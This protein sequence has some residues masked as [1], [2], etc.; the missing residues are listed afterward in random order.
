MELFALEDE[1]AL[2]YGRWS[3]KVRDT[4]VEKVRSRRWD[5]D[6]VAL[7]VGTGKREVQLARR[8]M[9]AM[10]DEG[11]RDEEDGGRV[12]RVDSGEGEF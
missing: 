11:D 8:D 12:D 6:Q 5:E 4:L 2:E 1:N 7:S 3:D 9:I 10:D